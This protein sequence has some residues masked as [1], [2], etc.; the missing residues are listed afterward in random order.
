MT[1]KVKRQLK[2]NYNRPNY[3]GKKGLRNQPLIYDETKIK[4]NLTLTPT[5]KNYLQL[6][7]KEQ[8]TSISSLIE[9]WARSEELKAFQIPEAIKKIYE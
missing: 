7:A 6:K 2:S 1:K 8:G 9:E 4:L 3:K 5:A